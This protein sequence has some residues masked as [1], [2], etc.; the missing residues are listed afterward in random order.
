MSLPPGFLWLPDALDAAACAEHLAALR[1]ETPWEDHALRIFGREVA[2]PRRIA[3]FGEHAY[4]Y[5]GVTHPARPLPERLE[6]L[7]RRVEVLA[8][9]P[10][11]VVL[12]NL[13][14][15]GRDSMGWHSDDDYPCGDHP[16]V[17]SLSFGATRRLRVRSKATPRATFGLD[18]TAGGLLLMSGRSQQD[19][20][21]AVP[22]TTR[23][24]GERLNLTFRFMASP[25]TAAARPA[26]R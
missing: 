25:Q 23:P 2:M 24:V 7:R 14:R 26:G 10:F 13:Y 6:A 11:N 18:L 5:S 4:A 1:A 20:Q 16:G 21:H 9:Q 17:A 22:K 3:F 19:W 12:L 8:G 15:D